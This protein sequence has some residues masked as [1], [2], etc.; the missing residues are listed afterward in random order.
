MSDPKS[1]VTG[2]DWTRIV[3]DPD[4]LGHLGELLKTYRDAPPTRRDEALVEAM[5]RI[6][7]GLPGAAPAGEAAGA[8]TPTPAP[9]ALPPEPEATPPFDPDDFSPWVQDRRRYPRMKC[10]V[11][12]ELRVERT[13]APVWGNLSN[14]SMGGAFVETVTPVPPGANVEIGLWLA[15]GKIWVKGIVLNGTVTS[16]NPCFG[17]RIR[18][19]ELRT[20]ERE[21][22]KQFLKFIESQTKGYNKDNG[23]LAQMK[24]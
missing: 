8:A 4:L 18:F 3:G 2:A 16:S 23:Y 6:K 13:T 15:T 10:F 12:V 14:T 7:L 20:A 17:V 5:R 11:A 22:L 24:R 9:Q 21:T 19:A 1:S